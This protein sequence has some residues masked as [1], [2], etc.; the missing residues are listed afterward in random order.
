MK[1]HILK[2]YDL[3]KNLGRA[4]NEAMSMI[5]EGDWACLMDLDT[6]F[7][8][9]DAGSILHS[10]ASKYPNT[11]IFTCKTNRI[12]PL[13]K[14]QLYLDAPSDNDS[15]SF[16][17]NEA[18]KL[19]SYQHAWYSSIPTVISGFLMMISKATWNEIK[20]S[21]SGKCLGVDNDFSQKVLASGRDIKCMEGLLVWHTYR[22]RDIK[23]KTHLL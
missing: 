17:I 14:C 22:L 12:H 21:E 15:I 19:S 5:P 9:P 8:T 16:W 23:D 1:V 4:Y 7:L 10:Y 20:F 13:Q 11:G 18:E 2:P 3:D 6:M